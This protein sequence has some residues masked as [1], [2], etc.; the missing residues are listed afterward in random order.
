MEPSLPEPTYEE[1][2]Y[3]R[4]KREGKRKED[5]SGL[6]VEWI[7]YKLDEQ[8]RVCPECGETMRDIGVTVRDEIK[9]I[10]AQVVHL[11]YAVHALFRVAALKIFLAA[12]KSILQ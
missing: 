7:E 11:E 6:P 1:I 2:T 8:E 5:L 9:I 12:N 3:T 4:K 10:P